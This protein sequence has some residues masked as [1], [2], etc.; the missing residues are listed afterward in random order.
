MEAEAGGG[1]WSDE[2]LGR[3]REGSKGRLEGNE[4]VRRREG[5]MRGEAWWG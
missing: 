4:V 1:G 3:W 5:E 2:M